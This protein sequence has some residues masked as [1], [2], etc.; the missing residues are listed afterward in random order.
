MIQALV[1]T[2]NIRLGRYDHHFSLLCLIVID[3]KESY[4][5]L[6]PGSWRLVDEAKGWLKERQN[7]VEVAPCPVISSNDIVSTCILTQVTFYSFIAK[8]ILMF[9]AIVCSIKYPKIIVI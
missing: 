6:K 3:E 4:I 5:T 7:H 2:T 8:R 1:F 9:K